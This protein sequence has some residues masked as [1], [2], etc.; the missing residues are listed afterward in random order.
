MGHIYAITNSING[1]KYIGLTRQ[2]DPNNRWKDHISE[3]KN[4]PK[5]P[6]HLAIKKYGLEN[7][8]FEIIEICEE[9]ILEEREIFYIE[10]YN[11]FYDG[12]NATLG[13]NISYDTNT[14]TII[15][16]DK[17]GKFIKKYPS[18]TEAAID[19]NG[20]IG[21][22]GKCANGKRF[23]AYGYR[24][25]WE[26]NELKNIKKYYGYKKTK[27]YKE[28]STI[29]EISEELQCDI[30]SVRY[31]IRSSKDN[32]LQIKGWY[33]F[34]LDER[35][36]YEEITFAERYRPNKEKAREMG[37]IRSQQMWKNKKIIPD[38]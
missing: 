36:E 23:S 18:V 12:Y 7:F 25:S 34:N 20:C 10:K 13:G 15:C 35:L 33:I 1:K 3:S 2:K 22:I 17:K 31:S 4:N 26:E 32:K 19:V 38:T 6:I 16:Y 29:M 37:K 28:W 27:E 9:E 5:Y 11:T 14:K 8:N 21:A 30:S 24:W